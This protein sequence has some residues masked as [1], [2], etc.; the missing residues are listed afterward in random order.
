MTSVHLGPL[1]GLAGGLAGTAVV[2]AV[3]PL[4]PVGWTA[5]AVVLLVSTWLVA[6]GLRRR[7]MSRFGPANAI[8]CA[9]ASLTGITT[10]LAV[11]S[12]TQPV[13]PA[14]VVAIVGP[15]LVLDGIDGGV[16]RRTGTVSELGA[17]Y[18]ME[19]DAFLLLV[20]G[21]YV[22]RPVG[23]WVLAI[24]LMRYGFVAAA[25]VLPWMRGTLPA[26]YWR[27]VVAAT[28]GVVLVV[29]IADVLPGSVAATMLAGSLGLLAESFGRDVLWLW[30]HR[31]AVPVATGQPLVE[32][33]RPEGVRIRA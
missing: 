3:V 29:A 11:T 6:A 20:L 5:G 31:T 16:A 8:T 25:W 12:L 9:R 21:V 33:I 24:G 23:G 15:A 28:Q 27:K 18:D 1:A 19:V 32:P 14:I 2:A 22:A 26:R 10:A 30:R 17:R 4:S 7:G 13:A